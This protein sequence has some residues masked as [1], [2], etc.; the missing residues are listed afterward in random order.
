MAAIEYGGAANSLFVSRKVNKSKTANSLMR[1]DSTTAS[2]N[3]PTGMVAFRFCLTNVN[4]IVA[5][6]MRNFGIVRRGLRF[7][8]LERRDLLATFIVT[9]N[10]A[11]GGSQPEPS[12]SLGW[13][14]AQAN[15]TTYPGWDEIK[16]DPTQMAGKTILVEPGI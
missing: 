8:C 4:V 9:N 16:F 12:G 13:A 6:S 3:T 10:D 15:S 11:I 2:C 7:E 5:Y 1:L 14:I